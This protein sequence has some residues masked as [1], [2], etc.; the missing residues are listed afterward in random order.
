[1]LLDAL[2]ILAVLEDRPESVDDRALVE[3]VEGEGPAARRAAVAL[4]GVLAEEEAR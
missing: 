4:S 1:M 2:V 3:A